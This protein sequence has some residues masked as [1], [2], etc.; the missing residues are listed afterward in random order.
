M[1]TRHYNTSP[2]SPTSLYIEEVSQSTFLYLTYKEVSLRRCGFPV[3]LINV[4]ALVKRKESQRAYKLTVEKF[5]SAHLQSLYFS[6][7]P[8][9]KFSFLTRS[10]FLFSLFCLCY[11]RIGP[12]LSAICIFSKQSV[13]G[14]V[15]HTSIF[16]FTQSAS[17]NRWLI[18]MNFP[19]LLPNWRM[20]IKVFL[21]LCSR[22]ISVFVF[23]TFTLVFSERNPVH[24]MY[25]E[26]Q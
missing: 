1:K 13:Y 7:L 25:D 23:W 12:I 8:T 11:T 14:L 3:Y 4:K 26:T 6:L 22:Y 17:N 5:S 20:I 24:I 16:Q 2:G 18:S 21:V 19:S 9:W 10:N 15:I